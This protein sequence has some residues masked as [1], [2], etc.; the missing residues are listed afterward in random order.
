MFLERRR[1][2]CST[3]SYTSRAADAG[4]RTVQVV[5]PFHGTPPFPSAP[6]LHHPEM[7][8]GET[9]AS[10][11]RT[12]GRLRDLE[13]LRRAAQGAAAII[14][15]RDGL[16][17]VSGRDPPAPR[18]PARRQVSKWP[19]VFL[20]FAADVHAL[21]PARSTSSIACPR[22][23]AF[24]RSCCR[25]RWCARTPSSRRSATRA[26]GPRAVEPLVRA[27]S[28]SSSTKISAAQLREPTGRR[29]P[30]RAG[31]ETTRANAAATLFFARG[32]RKRLWPRRRSTARPTS[33]HAMP[34]IRGAG[35]GLG[36]AKPHER[37]RG[38]GG[39]GLGSA[40][41][42]SPRA[43][44]RARAPR[45]REPGREREAET[46]A[47]SH[48][49]PQLRSTLPRDRR[50]RSPNRRALARTGGKYFERAR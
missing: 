32:T 49:N 5:D 46:R 50:R 10:R 14:H 17:G 8:E 44:A 28:W 1:D 43:G 25:C 34:W 27:T 35:G 40:R 18:S 20:L 33:V 45:Q 29:V 22:S 23:L 26:P 11:G 4:S 47:K 7:L 36:D 39:S 9:R 21:R 3:V 6:E 37:P 41:H 30:L 13:H 31:V 12:A 38:A 16:G 48:R 2:A 19:A 24:P 15:V 42:V